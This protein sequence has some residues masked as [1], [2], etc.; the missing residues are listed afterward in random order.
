MAT[1]GVRIFVCARLQANANVEMMSEARQTAQNADRRMILAQ[2][3]SGRAYGNV[4]SRI[5]YHPYSGIVHGIT[6]RARYASKKE[7]RIRYRVVG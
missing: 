3:N 6:M 2:R 5:R 4:V 1:E 7:C